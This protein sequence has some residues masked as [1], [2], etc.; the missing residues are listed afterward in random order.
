[1]ILCKH[2]L[3][4]KMKTEKIHTAPTIQR[5]AVKPLYSTPPSSSN[6]SFVSLWNLEFRPTTASN[7]MYETSFVPWGLDAPSLTEAMVWVIG[8]VTVRVSWRSSLGKK[9]R[10]IAER[11]SWGIG[12]PPKPLCLVRIVG[13]V[14]GMD[15]VGRPIEPSGANE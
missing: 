5:R 15:I 2:Q 9:R 4:L 7:D 13:I 1:M 12:K 8:I 3:D 6:W 14:C 11:I 10:K